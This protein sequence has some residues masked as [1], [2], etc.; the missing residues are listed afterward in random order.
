M[1]NDRA[2]GS[3]SA[4]V[5]SMRQ[6]AVRWRPDVN[7]VV[8]Q[9]FVLAVL[10]VLLVPTPARAVDDCG[11]IKRL[12]NTLGAS[13]ARNRM[14]IAASQASGDNPQQAEE[15]SALLARQTKDFRELRED[16]VRNQCGDDWD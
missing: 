13:M 15:A 8:V 7:T 14:L 3:R 6:S 10:V 2:G 1:T 4:Q 9:S 16:Y 5:G 11:L 12:M